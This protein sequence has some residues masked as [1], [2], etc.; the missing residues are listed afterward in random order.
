MNKVE[1]RNGMAV[2]I[3]SRKEGGEIIS[4]LPDGKVLVKAARIK[5]SAS[6]FK[7][8]VENITTTPED[9]EPIKKQRGLV[10]I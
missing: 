5:A 8:E 6:G 4:L 3:L 7:T 9:L 1:L 2:I 10:I